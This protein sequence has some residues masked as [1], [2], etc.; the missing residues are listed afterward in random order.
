M[1]R[2]VLARGALVNLVE[3]PAISRRSGR[4]R[5]QVMVDHTEAHVD[6]MV[7]VAVAAREQL[8]DTPAPAEDA[9]E[10]VDEAP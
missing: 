9:P 5:L 7:A 6:K 1:T 8:G 10:G 4:W 2:A 3:H